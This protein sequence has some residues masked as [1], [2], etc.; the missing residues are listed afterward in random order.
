[1]KPMT[2]VTAGVAERA[3]SQGV[4]QVDRKE[5]TEP[6]FDE[7]LSGLN[8]RAG[9]V[10]E[11]ALL[12]NEKELLRELIHGLRTIRYGS[13]V[14]TVHEGRLVEINKTVRIRRK[15]GTHKE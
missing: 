15:N 11:T 14:L 7:F 1:M 10:A 13:I 9:D 3:A 8:G 2:R 12:A 5:N 4:E 6:G